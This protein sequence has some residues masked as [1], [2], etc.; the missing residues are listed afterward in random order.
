MRKAI[1]QIALGTIALALLCI[2]LRFAFFNSFS[3]YVPAG[4][5]PD[6]NADRWAA[7]IHID[8]PEVLSTGAAV[9]RNGYAQIPVYALNQ[10]KTALTVSTDDEAVSYYHVL[11]V[12]RFRSVYDYGTGNFTGDTVIVIGITAFWLLVS[13]IMLWH[14]FQAKGT[15]FYDHSTIYYA[16]FSL[17]ALATGLVMLSV[18]VSHRLHPESYSMYSAY[19]AISGASVRYMMLTTPVML[20]FAAAMAVSNIAL[21]R[22]ERPR[23]QNLLGL[24]LSLLLLIG[25]AIGWYLFT[26]NSSGSDW[27]G[28]LDSALQ[29]TYATLFIYGQCMLTGAVICGILAARHVPAADKDFIII[30]GCWFRPDGSLPPLLRGRADRALS[31]WKNQR[32]K[33]GRE[34][35]LIPSGGQGI[36]EP[37]PEAEAIRDYLLS[38]DVEDRLILPETRSVNTLQ[39][40]EFSREIIQKTD[41]EGKT[42]FAT[43][44][45][46]VFRSG[47]LAREAGLSAE[48]IGS[49]TKWWFWPNAF[50]RETAGLL[51]KRWKQEI[52]FLLVLIAFFD[53]LS[54]VLG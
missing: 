43:S 32:E 24:L 10:G 8:D 47:I 30:L 12:D 1:K 20:F 50:V 48:G 16:G 41:P 51:Q 7:R 4:H 2:V 44:S 27:Q 22:H 26:R 37:M 11:K 28:R 33:A 29:N 15:A 34:A 54:M 23:L 31:F 39:N 19:A 53:V 35:R 42:I 9:I 49:R 18:T 3:L 25:E 14:F 45:Y 36:N 46:H 52:L 17:F 40:M 6:G 5:D 13:A 38:R 21:L